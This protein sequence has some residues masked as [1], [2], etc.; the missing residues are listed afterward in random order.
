M[1]PEVPPERV[2][3]IRSALAETFADPEFLAEGERMGL[4]VNAPRTGAQLQDVI[5]RAY[6]S[7]PRIIERLQKLNNP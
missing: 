6:Q 7:P 2:A 1:P 4:A 5:A 3:A